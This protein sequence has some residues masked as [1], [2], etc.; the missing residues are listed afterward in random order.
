[1]STTWKATIQVLAVFCL[2]TA[3]ILIAARLYP[4]DVRIAICMAFGA[5]LLIVAGVTIWTRWAMARQERERRAAIEANRPVWGA[6][7][8]DHLIASKARVDDERVVEVMSHAE[9]WGQQVSLALLQG[10]IELG[11]TPDM[12]RAAMGQPARIEGGGTGVGETR[13]LWA[14][15][16]P[17]KGETRV[18]F[19]EDAVVLIEM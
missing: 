12:V 16:L 2:I 13:Y 7:I 1:M 19:E 17:G 9:A 14:Y 3:L 15:G 5:F 11:M 8:C 18:W 4:G 10:Q 6:E